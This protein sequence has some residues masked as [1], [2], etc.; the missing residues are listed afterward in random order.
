MQSCLLQMDSKQIYPWMRDAA[1]GDNGFEN[2]VVFGKDPA[3]QTPVSSLK[4][5]TRPAQHLLRCFSTRWICRWS[6]GEGDEQPRPGRAATRG[7]AQAARSD[8]APNSEF[9]LVG[10]GG[11]E[12]G[13]GQPLSAAHRSP[14]PA[15][16]QG[17]LMDSQER[18][19]DV[20]PGTP[21]SSRGGRSHLPTF[22]G[23]RVLIFK[24]PS[25]IEYY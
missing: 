2:E 3:T 6:G 25:H 21:S 14:E 24:A 22:T 20:V 12:P 4:A 9:V 10:R 8:P 5:R 16:R 23:S 18:G 19:R 1:A 13:R 11:S 17:T 15:L 7:E